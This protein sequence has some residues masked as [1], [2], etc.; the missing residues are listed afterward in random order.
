MRSIV[1]RRLT[2]MVKSKASSERGLFRESMIWWT[3]RNGPQ[4]ALF[5]R[6]SPQPRRHAVD[7]RE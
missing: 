1:P 5:G 6:L 4:M 2:A 7:G 3:I